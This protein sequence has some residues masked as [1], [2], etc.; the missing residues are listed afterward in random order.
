[1]RFKWPRRLEWRRCGL[2]RMRVGSRSPRFSNSAFAIWSTR[3]GHW[4]IR[5]RQRPGTMRAPGGPAK[6]QW[7]A[8]SLS[9][10]L[11]EPNAADTVFYL[12]SRSCG[13]SSGGCWPAIPLR[14]Q[15]RGDVHDAGLRYRIRRKWTPE[16]RKNYVRG[17]TA[18]VKAWRRVACG[19]S[20]GRKS[21]M[22]SIWSHLVPSRPLLS[23]LT[24]I[25]NFD[26][27]VTTSVRLK[28]IFREIGATL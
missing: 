2:E 11:I 28:K 13:P 6:V 19:S 1:M 23:S 10:A 22:R 4:A 20:V 25:L 5:M 8:F 15:L 17:P 16:M 7:I 14:G 9:F 3:R 26:V 12:L 24:K 18:P 21:K 27:T